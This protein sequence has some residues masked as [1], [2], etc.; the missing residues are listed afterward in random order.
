MMFSLTGMVHHNSWTS[1]DS[2]SY[3]LFVGDD[4]V[5]AIV[6]ISLS[7]NSTIYRLFIGE[8]TVAVVRLH[9]V[10]DLLYHL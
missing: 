10:A 6:H 3:R 5:T 1:T 2:V 4:T 7:S 9:M 8:V